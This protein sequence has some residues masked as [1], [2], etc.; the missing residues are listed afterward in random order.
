MQFLGTGNIGNQNFNF[1]EQGNRAIYSGV[2]GN[3]YLPLEGLNN[4]QHYVMSYDHTVKLWDFGKQSA[5]RKDK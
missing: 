3:E 5:C 1:G 2:Q 4:R